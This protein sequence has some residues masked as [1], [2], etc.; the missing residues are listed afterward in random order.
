MK[1][2]CMT[3]AVVGISIYVGWGTLAGSLE[4]FAPPAATDKSQ[5]SQA[6]A[7]GAGC[8]PGDLPGYPVTIANSGSYRLTS[9]L[10]GVADENGITI[11]A[12]N[13]TLDLSGFT[14]AGTT[15]A[16][17]G[18]GVVGTP[19]RNNVHI[20]NGVIRNFENGVFSGASRDVRVTD[21]HA[22]D[23]VEKGFNIFNG[24]ATRCFARNNGE[25][26][27][28]SWSVVTDCIAV[29]NSVDG[30]QLNRSTVSGSLSTDNGRHG[31]SGVGVVIRGCRAEN[32]GVDGIN[33]S[34]GAV[35]TNSNARFNTN[36][37]IEAVDSLV[38]GNAVFE[39]SGTA[40]NATGSTLVE[41]HE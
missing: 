28:M 7:A 26:F 11:D 30:F 14:L 9:N 15:G 32:N 41:N 8:F 40:I 20:L 35:V 39:N 6:C 33:V 29:E 27:Q 19:Q 36:D 10:S 22:L 16:I 12:D 18:V 2:V 21:V 38:R 37:G 25:G 4:P 23:N 3:V 34:D 13:V 1:K 24:I 5:I 31:F 17:H